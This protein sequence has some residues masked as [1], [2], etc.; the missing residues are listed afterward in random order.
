MATLGIVSALNDPGGGGTPST[1]WMADL[2]GLSPAPHH[3]L[4]RASISVGADNRVDIPALKKSLQA[5]RDAGFEVWL[6][7]HLG[8]ETHY[9]SLKGNEYL[10]AMPNANLGLDDGHGHKDFLLNDYINRFS[11]TVVGTLLALGDL[12]PAVVWIGN[13]HNLDGPDLKM[14][15]RPRKPQSLNPKVFGALLATTAK[16]IRDKVPAVKTI[17]PGSLTCLIKYNTDPHG[18]WVGGYLH[19]SLDYIAQYGVQAPYDFSC[20]SLNLEGFV[21][22]QYA[23][24]CAHA[25]SDIMRDRKI[26][27]Q[28]II[29]EFG[30]N[31]HDATD[32][33]MEASLEAVDA[34]FS[35][36][37]FYCHNTLDPNSYGTTDLGFDKGNIVPT[38]HTP[39][40]VRFATF[41]AKRLAR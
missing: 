36:A 30:L 39:W 24:Y 10:A 28:T 9:Q 6:S 7:L 34:H 5:Y 23:A 32:T 22:D 14:G 19:E 21:T 29:G 33:N 35:V 12:C 40:Y 15:W 26:S 13:E 37:F 38:G 31:N 2:A 8:L 20:L 27:G 3:L 11:L 16:R 18:P 4:I 25:L 17:I 1:A 41:L